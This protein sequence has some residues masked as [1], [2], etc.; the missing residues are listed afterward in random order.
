M[1]TE[2]IESYQK[3]WNSHDGGQVAAF[4]AEHVVY[5]DLLGGATF[6]GREAVR[7]YVKGVHE[8][9]SDY[10][11]VVVTAQSSGDRYA[12]EWEMVGT[13]T[14]GFGGAPPTG[15]PY[16]IR[17]LSVGQLDGE[18]KIAANRDYATAP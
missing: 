3:A 15:Q 4:M 10:R 14:G 1:G 13:D 17:G 11:F 8:W 2:W 18:G 5:E 7:R 12:F 16:R 6:E 9:S